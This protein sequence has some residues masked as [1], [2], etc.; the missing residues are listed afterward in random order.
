LDITA[1]GYTSRTIQQTFA[2]GGPTLDVSLELDPEQQEWARLE[3][4]T[5]SG[6]LQAFLRK[7][8]AGKH[9][10]QA[11]TKLDALISANRNSSANVVK[12]TGSLTDGGMISDTSGQLE[13]D[14][15]AILGVLKAYEKS[16]EAQDLEGL[17]KLWPTMSAKTIQGITDFFKTA[18]SIKLTSIVTDDPKIAGNEATLAFKQETSYVMNG[19]FQKTPAAKVNMKLKK[20]NQGSWQIDLIH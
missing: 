9:T 2:A 7:Y 13:H 17:Q 5:D 19:K 8:P 16:Y 15:T 18:K 12:S 20:T 14:K 4:S 10:E 1:D 3:S 11:K 6:A